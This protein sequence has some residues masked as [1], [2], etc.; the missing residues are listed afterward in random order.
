MLPVHAAPEPLGVVRR[1]V[2]DG[3]GGLQLRLRLGHPRQHLPERGVGRV[4]GGIVVPGDPH[5]GPVRQH[6][7]SPSR[8]DLFSR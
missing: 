3:V 7:S 4:P 8:P 1:R 2:G 5:V 6:S